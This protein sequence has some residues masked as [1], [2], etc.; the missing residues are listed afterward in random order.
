M[1]C[2]RKDGL[3]T[4]SDIVMTRS[5]VFQAGCREVKKKV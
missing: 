4:S 3:N 5:L 1:A 2:F